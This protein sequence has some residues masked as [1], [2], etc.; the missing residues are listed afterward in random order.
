MTS[1][2]SRLSESSSSLRK[3][4]GVELRTISPLDQ[5][6]PTLVAINALSRRPFERLAYDL[7]GMAEPIDGRG[8]D[9][10]DAEVERVMDGGDG[11]LLFAAA[12][13]PAADGPGAERDAR[14]VKGKACNLQVFHDWPLSRFEFVEQRFRWERV[15]PED[16]GWDKL[17]AR[18]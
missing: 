2:F 6:R 14:R 9:E 13:H 18:F 10:I 1:V 8:V 3:R 12:P 7:L 5:S 17:T 16:R 15:P 4:A 11:V